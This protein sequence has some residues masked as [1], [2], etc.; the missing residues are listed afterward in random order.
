VNCSGKSQICNQHQTKFYWFFLCQK[1]AVK[2][3]VVVVFLSQSMPNHRSEI[4]AAFFLKQLSYIHTQPNLVGRRK[5]KMEM[6][7]TFSANKSKVGYGRLITLCVA[8]FLTLTLAS[9]SMGG[10]NVGESS[11]TSEIGTEEFGLSKEELVTTIEAV[12]ANIAECMNEAGFEYIAADYNTVRRGMTADKSLPGLSEEEYFEQYGYGISTLYTGLPPQ[13]AE[14]TS[15]AQIGLGER[16]IQIFRNLGSADQVA[17]NQ[18]LFGEY[19]DATF[20]VALEIEDFSRTGGCTRSAIEQVFTPEQLSLSSFSPKD[21]VIEQDPRMIAAVAKYVECIKEAGFDYNHEK[22]I[23]PDLR[24]RLTEITGYAPLDA[25]SADAMAELT[26]LQGYERTL[27]VVS[28]E[29]EGEFIEP[30][31]DQIEREL[32]ANQ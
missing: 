7:L 6:F 14:V 17:Y 16:N 12:E 21:Q 29:C 19:N 27:A 1:F 3:F 9:C 22:E 18:I 31:E 11:S 23:E 30:V 8:L 20:A 13:L 4:F 15:P 2:R 5:A 24:D 32:F 28:F 26:E 10:G 25:L